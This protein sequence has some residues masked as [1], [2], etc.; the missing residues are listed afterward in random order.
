VRHLVAFIRA[1][2]RGVVLRRP[3]G[4]AGDSVVDLEPVEED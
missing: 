3:A 2:E 4:R 1:S